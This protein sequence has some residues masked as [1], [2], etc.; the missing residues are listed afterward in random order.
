MDPRRHRE[1]SLAVR[2]AVAFAGRFG[3]T[4]G[5]ALA[6]FSPESGC[7]GFGL[8]EAAEDAQAAVITSDERVRTRTPSFFFMATPLA[9]E[10]RFF[11]FQEGIHR[12]AGLDLSRPTSS[13]IVQICACK[14]G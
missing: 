12:H 4:F 13:G 3:S 7:G 1:A 9:T 6:Q 11:G 5:P 2:T 14:K 8:E 10:P